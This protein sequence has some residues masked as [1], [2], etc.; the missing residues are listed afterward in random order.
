M[1]IPILIFCVFVGIIFLWAMWQK[2]I[3]C[4]FKPHEMYKSHPE[5]PEKCWYCNRE[6]TQ[7]L[8]HL[9]TKRV[10]HEQRK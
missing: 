9:N 2:E 4:I 7:I 1:P 10:D 8:L 6:R 3:R 5:L